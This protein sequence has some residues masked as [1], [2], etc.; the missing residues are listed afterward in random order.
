VSCVVKVVVVFLT[1][2]SVLIGHLPL[3]SAAGEEMTSRQVQL[4]MYEEML[5]FR[6]QARPPGW[7]LAAALGLAESKGVGHGYGPGH[8]PGDV[9]SKGEG[10]IDEEEDE[11]GGLVCVLTAILRLKCVR[12]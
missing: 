6:P 12:T 1:T 11:V 2:V 7:N 10:K 9:W 8:G 5:S 3:G 4:L